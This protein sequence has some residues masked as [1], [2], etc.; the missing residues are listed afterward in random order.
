MD[1]SGGGVVGE[2]QGLLSVVGDG[3]HFVGSCCG[4]GSAFFPL[5]NS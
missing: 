4:K 1:S 2:K 3:H 5:L